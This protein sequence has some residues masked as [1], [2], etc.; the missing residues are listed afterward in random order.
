MQATVSRSHRRTSFNIDGNDGYFM[1]YRR[2]I[3]RQRGSRGRV[4]QT[5][6]KKALCGVA[7]DCKAHQKAERPVNVGKC[8]FGFT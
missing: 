5:T 4:H 7:W 8:A 3:P 1:C 2:T 6:Y